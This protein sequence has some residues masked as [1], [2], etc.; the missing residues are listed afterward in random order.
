MC[1]TE[2]VSQ[3]FFIKSKRILFD[4]ICLLCRLHVCQRDVTYFVTRML[5]L[6]PSNK[7]SIED[8]DIKVDT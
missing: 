4:I 2:N 3:P 6:P 5:L 1:V 7:Y 8:G